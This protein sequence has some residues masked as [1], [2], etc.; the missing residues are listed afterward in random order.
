MGYLISVKK[1]V[2]PVST[3]HKVEE[4]V[5]VV[6]VDSE[7]GKEKDFTFI[8][9]TTIG[10][11]KVDWFDEKGNKQATKRSEV[12]EKCYNNKFGKF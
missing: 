1:G 5:S 4:T 11:Y 10:T 9:V 2:F 8:R 7:T 12:L 3:V 6:G